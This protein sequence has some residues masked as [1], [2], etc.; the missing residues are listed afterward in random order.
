M[1]ILKY[2]WPTFEPKQ[3]SNI[4]SVYP[5]NS[6][7]NIFCEVACFCPR[8]VFRKDAHLERGVCIG[9]IIWV[10]NRNALGAFLREAGS[11][12]SLDRAGPQE[13][14]ASLVSNVAAN[15]FSNSVAWLLEV[16]VEALLAVAPP[17]RSSRPKI[18]EEISSFSETQDQRFKMEC[19]LFF[20]SENRRLK[21]LFDHQGRR[22]KIEPSEIQNLREIGRTANVPALPCQDLPG[23][24]FLGGALTLRR[25]FSSPRAAQAWGGGSF[26]WL[27]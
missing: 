6:N 18:E 8:L 19:Y 4:S 2:I 12:G 27:Y 23:S 11:A 21:L 3:D 17:V 5:I 7:I 20:E 14:G 10:S 22:S 25:H 13:A 1:N 15:Y 24:S 26:Q 16:L 9:K